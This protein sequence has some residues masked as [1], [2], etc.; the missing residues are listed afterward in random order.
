MSVVGVGRSCVG[1]A[2]C[3]FSCGVCL[4]TPLRPCSVRRLFCVPA[5]TPTPINRNFPI[6]STEEPIAAAPKPVL[7]GP[8]ASLFKPKPSD[9]ITPTGP[10]KK[11]MSMLSKCEREDLKRRQ[12]LEAKTSTKKARPAAEEVAE[13]AEGEAAAATADAAEAS[14]TKKAEP[15]KPPKKEMSKAERLALRDLIALEKK[16]KA[17]EKVKKAEEKVAAKEAKVAAE[18]AKEA[19][20]AAKAAL[21]KKP[22]S[23]YI[24]F[25]V[26]SREKLLE[27]NPEL[28]GK[29]GELAKLA[30][31]AWRELSEE[32][33][34][35]YEAKAAADKERYVAECEAAGIDPKVSKEKGSGGEGTKAKRSGGK[36]RKGDDLEELA[37]ELGR[38]SRRSRRRGWRP[39]RRRRGGGGGGGGGRGDGRADGG[40]GGGGGV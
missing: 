28:K 39:R 23:A 7:A 27:E 17:E 11:A 16:Q 15:P 36:K 33:R 26:A 5:A 34:L 25:S 35:P 1:G 8:W 38:R 31:A 13:G 6:M 19:A 37:E 30:G 22:L 12:A 29:T 9:V 2:G 24:I 32:E 18:E 10:A 3:D 14:S 4:R 20:K 40:G 21:P